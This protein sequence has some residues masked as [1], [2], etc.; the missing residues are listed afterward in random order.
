MRHWTAIIA[1]IVALSVATSVPARAQDLPAPYKEVLSFLA[2]SGDFKDNVLK[3][4]IPRNDV[5]V[6]VAGVSTPTPFGF[7]GW[8]AMTKGDGGMDVLMGDLVLT[9][10][11]VNPVMSAVLNGGLDLPY[12]I[13]RLIS[14]LDVHVPVITTSAGTMRTAADLY[15]VAPRL[16]RSS[17]RK[18]ETAL[19]LFDEHV[20][21]PALL[22]RLD[23]SPSSVVTPSAARSLSNG[24]TMPARTWSASTGGA[25]VMP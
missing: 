5:T 18:V 23:V 4:N 15:A 20:D 9:E 24:R 6:T 13:E 12:S 2:K 3:V 1:G 7:G 17:T 8:I 19:R 10:S 25:F 22:D 16:T 21:G 11:E 14:G